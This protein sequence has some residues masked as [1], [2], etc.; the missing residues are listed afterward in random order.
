MKNR[1]FL[2]LIL[3]CAIAFVS[4]VNAVRVEDYVD[5]YNQWDADFSSGSV[6][7]PDFT[8]SR[9][10]G[11][12]SHLM[13]FK[14]INGTRAGNAYCVFPSRPAPDTKI[15]CGTVEPK[16][17]PITYYVVYN[18]WDELK[19]NPSLADYVMRTAG[20]FDRDNMLNVIYYQACNGDANC[21]KQKNEERSAS[22]ISYG[23]TLEKAFIKS[24]QLYA[25]V[26]DPNRPGVNVDEGYGVFVP[27]NGSATLDRG[28]QILREAY[29]ARHDT[30]NWVLPTSTTQETS[31]SSSEIV[32]QS[33]TLTKLD[34]YEAQARESYYGVRTN[35]G[36]TIEGICVQDI[37]G[38]SE[39]ISW[40]GSEGIIKLSAASNDECFA[41]IK[42]N[43]GNCSKNVAPGKTPTPSSCPSS[44][45][46]KC[47]TKVEKTRTIYECEDHTQQWY[48]AGGEACAS[49][50]IEGGCY[51]NCRDGSGKPTPKQVGTGQY[52]YKNCQCWNTQHG[53]QCPSG[54]EKAPSNLDAKNNNKL[55][56]S[57]D[58][59]SEPAELTIDHSIPNEV[60]DEIDDSYIITATP[61]DRP[62]LKIYYCSMNG[63]D[64]QSYISIVDREV[65]DDQF[66]VPLDCNNCYVGDCEPARNYDTPLIQEIHNCCEDGLTSIIRQAALD[67]LF[68]KDFTIGVGTTDYVPGY[69]PKCN[70][71][72]SDYQTFE[73]ASNPY[74]TM[75]CSD[76]ITYNIP[77]PTHAKSDM[78]FLFT[79]KYKKENNEWVLTNDSGPKYEHYRRCRT[80]IAYNVWNENYINQVGSIITTYNEYNR[81]EAWHQ[82][83]I[84]L[85]NTTATE[86]LNSGTVTCKWM[87]HYH[88]RGTHDC[89]YWSRGGNSYPSQA[90]CE[91]DC[92]N[93]LACTCTPIS[94]T[95]ND[96][97]LTESYYEKHSGSGDYPEVEATKYVEINYRKNY[98]TY[99]V[100]DT[101]GYE[102]LKSDNVLT[103][104][105]RTLL[106]QADV[107]KHYEGFKKA[108]EYA[109][110]HQG[111][112]S[113]CSGTDCSDI[114]GGYWDCTQ[115]PTYPASVKVDEEIARKKSDADRAKAQYSSYVSG[116]HL[117][118]NQLNECGG[119]YDSNG[120]VDAAAVRS[121]I[122]FTAD[123]EP[124]LEFSYA[125]SYL[126]DKNE[127]EVQEVAV[128][129]EKVDNNGNP[130]GGRCVITASSSLDGVRPSWDNWEIT[131]WQEDHYFSG[132]HGA[133][134]APRGNYT[135]DVSYNS[136]PATDT[137]GQVIPNY[138]ASRKY[139]TDAVGHM[140]CRWLDNKKNVIYNLIPNGLITV[141]EIDDE[142]ELAELGGKWSSRTGT[143]KINKTTATGKYEVY[144]TMKNIGGKNRNGVPKMYDDIVHEQGKTCSGRNDLVNYKGTPVNATCYIEINNESQ[145]LYD[146]T[147]SYIGLG[148]KNPTCK[149]E[150]S[151]KLDYKE[152]DP[153]DPF[154]NI[155][156]Y[157]PKTKD[158]Y[159]NGY[160]YNWMVDEKGKDAYKHITD[161]AK[162]DKTY[163]TEELTY[164]FTLKPKDL[165]AIR[166]YNS[167]RLK[168]GGYA[169]FNMTC[170]NENN[171]SGKPLTN[172]K[173]KF[174]EAI[175]GL[176]TEDGLHAKTNNMDLQKVRDRLKDK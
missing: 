164:S 25:M 106:E 168:N 113:N 30:E 91:S 49:K 174:L 85:K 81:L 130:T 23:T 157:N 149:S 44:A 67:E 31:E 125:Q 99:K 120:K 165:K 18:Y 122:T 173:S 41:E 95:C 92:T 37:K 7:R 57:S 140:S 15:T 14:E 11:Y 60:S 66:H 33:F 108:K 10:N 176:I 136:G 143:Y 87:Q 2:T 114:D 100:K 82:T 79:K 61:F 17:W 89:S 38:T 47:C 169:D 151:I 12:I 50:D 94:N 74:C 101:D 146:C 121:R 142:G 68:C 51:R 88:Y 40:S 162:L 77:G 32:G 129:F 29:N 4:S 124:E 58:I 27:K 137:Q 117:M 78:Y 72:N 167:K 154:P 103:E 48:W 35:D 59:G 134:Y 5:F 36:S 119:V 52:Y 159:S 1:L 22:S 83:W 86:T 116:L 21:I 160:A 43:I 155:D 132:D 56:I 63:V 73:L 147:G 123:D 9:Q 54:K 111:T 71:K 8:L 65:K 62:D 102:I 16:Y 84:S 34:G 115:D 170:D 46:D 75:Y 20:I 110:D 128:P 163:S 172:C 28:N 6:I 97:D 139:T 144:Y 138:I 98:K 26:D 152:V 112:S 64:A 42:I 135:T 19:N 39:I 96:D 166:E 69:N 153:K 3:I 127:V 45:P 150:M 118:Q 24:F 156:T 109:Q 133:L 93:P 55:D 80:T 104:A 126:N 76:T 145:A 148:D 70:V 161:N 131:G 90:D 158:G 175:S 53:G 141:E 107:E 13:T 171:N 105:T